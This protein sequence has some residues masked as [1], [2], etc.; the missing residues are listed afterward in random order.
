VKNVE[1]L[2]NGKSLGEKSVDKLAGGEWEVPYAPGK[3]EAIARVDGKE[4]ARAAV[5]TTGEPVALKLIPDRDA[6]AG[7]GADALPITV[8]AV[9]AAGRAVPTANLPVTFEISGPGVII[10]HGN[11]DNCSHEPEK[12]NHRI[13][14]NGLAQ[15]IVQ[16]QRDQSGSVTLTATADGLKSA[17][18]QIIVRPATSLPAVPPL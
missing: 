3:L 7:D 11:G 17:E 4:I 2:L 14:F 16:S 13:L 5:E 12:G 6:L 18:V 1:L 9:D 15:V 10:G 8:C